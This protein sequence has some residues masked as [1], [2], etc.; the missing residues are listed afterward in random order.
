VRI[1]IEMTDAEM[2]FSE[3]IDSLKG[4]GEILILRD[5]LPVARLVPVEDAGLDHVPGSAK[6]LF[7]VPDDFDA[8]LDELTSYM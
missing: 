8:P 7:V 4:G 6:G 1:E 3:L 2:R 5:G